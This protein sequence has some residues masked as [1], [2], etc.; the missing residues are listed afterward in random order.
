MKKP[1][2][3]HFSANIIDNSVIKFLSKDFEL[4]IINI[5]EKELKNP[6]TE[7][8]ERIKSLDLIIFVGGED[9]DP[10]YYGQHI[11]KYTQINR[12]RDNLEFELLYPKK[13]NSSII[14][15]IPKLGICRG[16]QLL[17]VYNGG[18]LIQHVEGH[19]NND[20]VIEIKI[21]NHNSSYDIKVSSDHHQ[22]M[23]PYN[24]PENYYELIGY[25][26]NFQSNTYLNGDNNE[27]DLPKNFLEPEIIYYPG[28]NSLCIQ[29][30]PE[31][32]IDSEGSNYCLSLIHKY[33][34]K[35]EIKEQLPAGL[36]EGNYPIGWNAHD[37]HGN[38]YKFDGEK[39][40]TGEEFDSVGISEF[41]IRK[42]NKKHNNTAQSV[43]S[44]EYISPSYEETPLPKLSSND[45]DT[46]NESYY[47]PFVSS[48]ESNNT[49][50]F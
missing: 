15:Q 35:N 42:E 13:T 20:Q 16:A 23:Y 5:S 44:Y 37:M 43:S 39:F 47:E 12:K 40:I 45:V 2:N 31:W 29:S 46:I 27:I 24:L 4:N 6:N 11:G 1:L 18:Q 41:I 48:Q 3:V 14:K 32:C 30:H 33:L 17:T 36:P 34:F 22:M 10:E 19:K 25:S 49:T 50:E 9:V 28:K 7:I 8:L 38:H 21:G 26:K